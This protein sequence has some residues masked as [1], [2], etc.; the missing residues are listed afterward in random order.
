MGMMAEIVQA[1]V[2]AMK[3][4]EEEKV[5]ILTQIDK[6]WGELRFT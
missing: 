5:A 3:I 1:A 4:T 6:G 2:M